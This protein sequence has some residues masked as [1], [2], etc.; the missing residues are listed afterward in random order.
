M[1]SKIVKRMSNWKS[2]HGVSSAI[3]PDVARAIAEN[4]ELKSRMGIVNKP[5]SISLDMY[6]NSPTS[7]ISSSNIGATSHNLDPYRVS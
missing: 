1:T 4:N 5:F 7:R 3:S 6:T 2:L